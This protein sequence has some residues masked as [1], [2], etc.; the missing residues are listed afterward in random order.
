MNRYAAYLALG[1]GLAAAGGCN[2]PYIFHVAQGQAAII[3]GSRPIEEVIAEPTS[4]PAVRA[5]LELVQAVKRFGEEEIGLKADSSFTTFTPIEGPAALYVVTA[6]QKLE[7]KPHTWT[8]PLVGS[9]PYKGFF[10]RSLA[11]AEQARLGRAGLD[12]NLRSAAAYSTL[13]WFSDPVLEP[14]LASGEVTIASVIL[15][16][17]THATVFVPSRVAFNEGLATFVGRRGAVAFFAAQDGE[18]SPR[19]TE[20]ARRVEDERRFG[21]FLREVTAELERLYGSGLAR[22]EKLERREAIFDKSRR[23][24]LDERDRYH[25]PDLV[26]FYTNAHINNAFLVS[27]QLYTVDVETYVMVWERHGRDLARTVE[28]FKTVGRVAE[29]PEAYVRRWLEASGP[30]AAAAAGPTR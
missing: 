25:Y 5:K 28:F 11:E 4:E 12:T 19:H 10:D 8:F 22:A 26:E 30:R 1:L 9:F 18:G 20:A 6:A 29:D 13:G 3:M 23:M 15:H 24:M 2:A 17:K 21:R 16:E 27:L 7:L 14:L